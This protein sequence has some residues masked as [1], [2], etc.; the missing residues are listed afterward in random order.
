MPPAL[1]VPIPISISVCISANRGLSLLTKCGSVAESFAVAGPMPVVTGFYEWGP[2]VNG[3]ARVT[4]PTGQVDFLYR[5]IDQ[6]QTVIDE[7]RLGV[8]RHDYDQQ[9]P[10]GFRSVVYL[11][12]SHICVPLYDPEGEIAA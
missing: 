1:R 4:T 7:S 10:F 3:G 2:W 11:G 5:H 9:P 8:W 12:E 6:L